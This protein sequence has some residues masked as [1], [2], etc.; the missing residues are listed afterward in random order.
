MRI[1][2]ATRGDVLIVEHPRA[3]I[4]LDAYQR[5]VPPTVKKNWPA[6]LPLFLG[7]TSTLPDGI[8]RVRI[9]RI[10]QRKYFVLMGKDGKP[11]GLKNSG[12]HRLLKQ[13]I[14]LQDTVQIEAGSALPLLHPKTLKPLKTVPSGHKLIRLFRY[15]RYYYVR[16]LRQPYLFAYLNIAHHYRL[17]R[18]NTKTL[19]AQQQTH[20]FVRQIEYFLNRKN[21]AYRELFSYFRQIT[22]KNKNQP[23]PAWQLLNKG[24]TFLLRFSA[25]HHLS[26]WSRSTRIFKR[27][28]RELCRQFHFQLQ[29][30]QVGEFIIRREGA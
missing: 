19:K 18:I 7:P 21:R 8:T 22:G 3:L 6:F 1:S 27:E 26:Q 24:N 25:P 10:L 14:F 9:V 28:L 23:P 20:E 5:S 2:G 12:F 17:Q 16:T 15:G 11:M 13:V 29:E 4:L 30:K